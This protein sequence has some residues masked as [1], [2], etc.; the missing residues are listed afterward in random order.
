MQENFPVALALMP[1]AVRGRL[2]AVYRYA[3]HVDTLGDEAA[4]DRSRLLTDVTIAVENLY[5]GRKVHDP[6]V[7]GLAD[8]V[9]ACRLPA[10]PLLNLIR[11]NLMDQEVTRYATFEDLRAYCRLSAD[12]VG[13]LVLHVFGAATPDRLTL[14]NRVCTALQLLEHWQDVREDFAAGRVYL[15]Q[16]DLHRFGV[17]EP[18]LA[19]E[20]AGERLRSLLAFE[21]D[22]AVGWLNAGSPL[23]ADLHGWARLAVSG[24]VAGGRAAAARLRAC[25]YDPLPAPPK[26]A[27]RHILAAWLSATVRYPG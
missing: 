24:Y 8:T 17:A 26:P 10:E 27:S 12:P 18:E 1:R 19:G 6:V 20:S 3:R 4:G 21:T 22:R 15:P 16:Q 11:A 25:G 2:W 14:S 13:E 5:A 9:R 23:V 7:A